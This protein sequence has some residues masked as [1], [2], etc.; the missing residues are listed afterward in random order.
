M[1]LGRTGFQKPTGRF[2]HPLDQVQKA[3]L[4]RSFRGR[5]VDLRGDEA[6]DHVREQVGRIQGLQAV[7]T[8]NRASP[9][10]PRIQLRVEQAKLALRQGVVVA[11]GVSQ[12]AASLAENL[13]KPF[14]QP[15]KTF[16][17]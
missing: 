6:R 16:R 10:V 3:S 13:S 5:R 2:W 7:L 15:F 8:Q 9:W 12:G 17:Q 11:S 14:R 1:G 4:E